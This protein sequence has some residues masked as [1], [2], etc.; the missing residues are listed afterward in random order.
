MSSPASNV[1]PVKVDPETL[2]KT[3]LE[4]AYEARKPVSRY[5]LARVVSERMQ[6]PI[7]ESEAIVEAY[8]EEKAPGIPAYLG[9]EFGIFWLKVVAVVVAAGGIGVFWY[10]A[11]LIKAHE[12]AYIPLIVGTLIC[13]LAAFLW[14]RSV[15]TFFRQEDASKQDTLPAQPPKR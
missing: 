9:S 15:E 1:A 10:A 2:L 6:L 3:Q 13:G 8:C 4:T 12:V 5:A 7:K 14:V 11:K